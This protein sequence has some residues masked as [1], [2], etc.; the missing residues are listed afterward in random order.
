MSNKT[1]AEP[2]LYLVFTPTKGWR[3][4]TKP[5]RTSS[6]MIDALCDH[7]MTTYLQMHSNGASFQAVDISASEEE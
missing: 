6:A 7:V 1:I 5:P 2:D 4:F 3:S